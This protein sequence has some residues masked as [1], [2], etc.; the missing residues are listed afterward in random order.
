[1]SIWKKIGNFGKKALKYVAPAA[2]LGASFIPG[3]GDALSGVIGKVG[4][5][6][7]NLGSSAKAQF[8]PDPGGA[9]MSEYAGGS[10]QSVTVEG[11][12]PGFDWTGAIGALT[13]V[14]AGAM[15]YFGQQNTNY[16]NAQQA[17]RQMDFQAS[18]TG[19]AYQRGVADM[20]AAG[21][22]PMLAYSQGGAQSGG[23]AQATMGNELGAGA[24]SAL[25]AATT[26]QEMQKRRSE[27]ENLAAQ[28][29]LTDA[30]ARQSDAQTINLG[31][32]TKNKGLHAI[33]QEII[34]RY[35]EDEK[36][37]AIRRANAAAGMDESRIPR[38]IAIS[39]GADLFGRGID[40]ISNARDAA[41]EGLSDLV[42]QAEDKIRS[43]SNSRKKH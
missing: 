38:E 6:L 28:T 37:S 18:Q 11:K 23:G 20:K 26:M 30:Q 33:T 4:G 22:N 25:S 12:R 39:K 2:A 34:N 31:A 17:Q 10:G 35:T 8:T 7:G 9:N 14:A 42:M 13:P 1:M 40:A 29:N 21:L 43:W 41:S 16:A 19:S 32:D 3:V 15:N 24:N 36:R 27:I 5:A